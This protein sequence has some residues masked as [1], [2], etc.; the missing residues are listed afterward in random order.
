MLIGLCRWLRFLGYDARL[1]FPDERLSRMENAVWLTRSRRRVA[2]LADFPHF[3]LPS[4]KIPEQL[5]ALEKHFHLSRHAEPLTR[6]TIC[7][8][9][10]APIEPDRVIGKVPL[11]ILEKHRFFFHC[12]E[13]NRIYWRGGHIDR[14]LDKLQRMGLKGIEL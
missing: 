9:P 10:V 6:C 11:R 14:L 13:C 4:D 7:N 3:L 12:P 5:K 1:P 2:E 8:V